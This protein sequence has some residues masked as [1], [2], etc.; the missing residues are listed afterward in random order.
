MGNGS[1][2]G[3]PQLIRISAFSLMVALHAV[4]LCCPS[5][6]NSATTDEVV[7]LSSGISHWHLGR[8]ELGAVNPP[9]VRIVGAFPVLS[10][11]PKVDWSTANEDPTVRSDLSVSRKFME[12][13]AA[14]LT[15]YFSLA[16]IACIPFSI[17]GMWVCYAWAKA[18]YGDRAG[19]FAAFLWCFSPMVLG[20]GSLITADVGAASLGAAAM[21]RFRTW[22][23]A[24]SFLNAILLGIVTGFAL[25]TKFIFVPVFPLIALLVLPLW[26]GSDLWPFRCIRRDFAHLTCAVVVSLMVVNTLY[27]F[28]GTFTPLGA[29]KFSNKLLR[30]NPDDYSNET[31]PNRL[32]GT[33][34][35]MLP[36][37]LPIL[38]VQ[39]IDMVGNDLAPN[40][41]T[42]RSYMMGRWK[43]GGW[44]YYYI[45]GVLVKEPLSIL[46]LGVIATIAHFRSVLPYPI[47][48]KA[49]LPFRELA[50]LAVPAVVIFVFVSS[51]TGFNRHLRYVLPAY[52]FA[53]ILISSVTQFLDYKK[54]VVFASLLIASTT[55]AFPHWLAYYNEA[56]GG[57]K[58]GSNWL[59][60][61]NTDWSQ[62]LL[63]LKRWMNEHPEA[64]PMKTM[65][66]CSR[67]SPTAIGIHTDP[68]PPFV[69]CKKNIVDA[70]GDRG[71]QPGWFAVSQRILK[72]SIH[73][74]VTGYQYFERFKPVDYAGYSILIYHISPEEADTV[75]RSLELEETKSEFLWSSRE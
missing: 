45:F 5:V 54:L 1:R 44:W 4:L 52:P 8:Y 37:P 46:V 36:V 71:P 25:L 61:S 60:G 73:S 24:S 39:G 34:L 63:R 55:F 26:R 32:S 3:Y 27:D 67:Y 66:N 6:I 19:L 65:L 59:L 74:N 56:A 21:F 31:A 28:E 68:P 35:G 11:K 17:L 58:N 15:T 51:Q 14:R 50:I 48:S 10:L 9:L 69:A 20:H 16:R 13:N 53:C 30:C 47:P 22:L 23:V 40:T 57:P 33:L 70:N 43:D 12:D 38:Y 62:D 64:A 72:E 41:M 18:I 49:Q 2:S 75:R 42:A 29:I 7:H